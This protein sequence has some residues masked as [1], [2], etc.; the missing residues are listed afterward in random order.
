MASSSTTTMQAVISVSSENEII[1]PRYIY[2]RKG[3]DLTELKTQF[4]FGENFFSTETP[5]S[6]IESDKDIEDANIILI[7][8]VE[9]PGNNQ[10]Y[11]FYTKKQEKLMQW[12]ALH[13]NNI[14]EKFS[15]CQVR[16]DA[17][18][19]SISLCNSNR[20]QLQQSPLTISKERFASENIESQIVIA[21]REQQSLPL[22]SNT[23]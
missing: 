14:Q 2:I 8:P 10:H 9:E 5:H 11:A 16:Y 15:C 6:I 12:I 19:E 4:I 13:F 21:I 18:T 23:K 1:L 20:I 22:Q 7:F 17:I 3:D